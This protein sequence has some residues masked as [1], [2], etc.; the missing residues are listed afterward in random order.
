M[1][2]NE[3]NLAVLS[4]HLQKTLSPDGATRKS[5][6][7]FL[8]SIESNQ[9]Y[10]LLL[11][12]LVDRDNIDL[13]LRV[14]GAVTFKNYV[15]RNW[16]I[17]E[18]EP[19]K[20]HQTDRDTVKQLI[21]S[22]MLKA[23]Q[24]VQRQ[25]GD[26]VS[27][28]GKEDFPA[29][30][31]NLITEMVEKFNTGDFHII[32]GVL[33]TAH[34]I[35]KRYRYESKSQELWEEIKLVLDRFAKPLTELFVA[36][37]GLAQ[38]HA[39][40]PQAV[41]I[42]FS[43]LTIISKI[44]YSLNYQDLPEFFEDNMKTWMENFLALLTAE[45][46]LL[47]TDSDDEPGLN[48]ELKSQICDIVSLYASKYDEEFPQFLP[49]FVTAVWNLLVTTGKE[50]KYDSLVSNAIGFLSSV[51]E[52]E[53]NKSLFS[54]ASILNSICEKVILPNIEFRQSDEELFEDN[55]EEYIRR[56]IEGSDVDTRR[57]AACDLVKA[58]SKS[59]EAPMTEIFG[60]YINAM[61]ESY[62]RDPKSNWRSK[63]AAIYLIIALAS[64]GQTARH[65][66]TQTNQLVDLVDF[67]SQH[68][69]NELQQ[70]NVNELMV[71]KADAIKYLMTFRNQLPREAI[72]VSIKSLIDLLRSNSIVVHSYAANAVD[73]IL[74]LKATDGSALIKRA[75]L[76]GTEQMLLMNLFYA[77]TIPGS[78]K[79]SSS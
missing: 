20:I 40:N 3:S 46:P 60:R 61:L 54:D 53:T 48:E 1:E 63:D 4:G 44:F 78:E 70:A 72:L 27:I 24:M 31:P 16:K 57:R 68:I 51:S 39:N 9:N 75:D 30:W 79:V 56:D 7:N 12:N 18:D 11:L 17:D 15:K 2:I 13:T 19:N 10:P 29:K 76:A 14:A 34:S 5:A 35:F 69:V 38:Q 26:A 71:L 22:L 37:M 62:A 21:I 58:L 33:H 45:N 55:A 49:Q 64:K 6:E 41:K 36:T 74:M 65:G 23:P 28:I 43:S 73:K 50:P 8:Q 32:N 67:F 77:M 59:F 47:K 66:T 42:I 25:L 52:R